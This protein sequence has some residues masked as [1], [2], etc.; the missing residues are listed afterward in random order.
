ML[1]GKN[2]TSCL[3]SLLPV[4]TRRCDLYDFSAL[5][6]SVSDSKYSVVLLARLSGYMQKSHAASAVRVSLGELKSSADGQY[7][8]IHSYHSNC[9]LCNSSFFSLRLR[10]RV[11]L[12]FCVWGEIGG[13]S[14][15]CGFH[16]PVQSCQCDLLHDAAGA[17]AVCQG[18]AE[19]ASLTLRQTSFSSHNVSVRKNRATT[20]PARPSGGGGGG[21]RDEGRPA[22]SATARLQVW[23]S[24]L[25]AKV[26]TSISSKIAARLQKKKLTTETRP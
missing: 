10:W 25:L 1:E 22:L 17:A 12:C 3:S 20:P 26:P 2:L 11:F 7:A 4:S 13:A 23:L 15:G 24:G 9:C 8:N 5:T 14:K 19:K 6:C 18:G 21:R 16:A